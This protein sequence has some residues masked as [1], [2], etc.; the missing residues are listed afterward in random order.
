MTDLSPDASRTGSFRPEIE[1]LRSVAFM[2]VAVF[3]IWFNRVSGGVDVFFT[4]AGFLVTT[5][6]LGHVRRYGR[7]RPGVYFGRLARRLLPA[8]VTVLVAT[9][10]ATRQLLPEAQRRDVLEQIAASALYFENWYLG[11]NAVD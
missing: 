6:L 8:A 4:V 7:I 3:H 2:L 9:T 11:L 5:T 10:L 1:G